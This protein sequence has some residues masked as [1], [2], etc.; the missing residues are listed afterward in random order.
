MKGKII[1]F[2][3]TVWLVTGWAQPAN[4]PSIQEIILEVRTN[5][6]R[7]PVAMDIETITSAL[8]PNGLKPPKV[9]QKEIVQYRSDGRRIDILSKR[10]SPDKGGQYISDDF[11][12]RRFF[13]GT[14][15]FFNQN[16]AGFQTFTLQSPEAIQTD[17][18]FVPAHG[19]CLDG[20][21][22]H[23]NRDGHWTDVFEKEIN[24]VVL[25]D[26]KE[27]VDG[28]FCLVLKADTA[29]GNYTLWLDPQEKY[30]LRK[31]HIMLDSNDR[32]WGKPLKESSIPLQCYGP[33]N[34]RHYQS[35]EVLL[36]DV[37]TETVSGKTIPVFG[38]YTEHWTFNDGYRMD[39]QYQIR[40]SNIVFNP[41]FGALGAFEMKMPEG[42]V[43]QESLGNGNFKKYTWSQGKLIPVN[44]K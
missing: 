11:S 39:N 25:L 43:F 28:V 17:A 8:D 40:R 6:Q 20:Y 13:N 32:V 38:L 19:N 5:L 9:L 44:K 7:F 23:N 31:V 2:C 33:D 36:G 14:V 3:L 21:F 10:F 41:D 4:D 18:A 27:A 29:C 37:K 24:S 1:A 42:T 35:M 34:R 30:C 16:S 15:A 26:E 22:S 12:T